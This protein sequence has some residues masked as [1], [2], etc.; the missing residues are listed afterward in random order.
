M[1]SI[2]VCH[3]SKYFLNQ[4]E[5]SII[6]TIG[7]LYEIVVIDNTANKYNIFQAYNLGIEQSNYDVICFAHEDIVFHTNG[8]GK[9]VI[10]HFT[11]PKV[12]I[13]GIAGSHYVPKLPGSHWNPCVTSCNIIHTINGKTNLDLTRYTDNKELS[14]PA[15]MLDGVWLCASRKVMKQVRFDDVTFSGFHCYDS[16]ICLQ[17]KKIRYDVRIV[18]DIDIEHF[19]FGSKD[20]IWLKNIYYWFNKW[21]S[22][23]P[24]SCIEL[25]KSEI[26]RANFLNAEELIEQIIINKFGVLNIIKTWSYY[27]RCNQPINKINL[28]YAF[29]LFTGMLIFLL[30][31]FYQKMKVLGK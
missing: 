20:K 9:K 4:L 15:V 25:S 17:I 3:R 29:R 5:Q 30:R 1:I 2:V 28:V 22:E 21:K 12:G 23:L 19:S 26:S 14:M 10:E 27:L 16:D 13:I 7:V 24:I 8:W 11:N 6:K 18:F 31:R